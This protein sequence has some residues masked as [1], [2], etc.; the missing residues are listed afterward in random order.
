VPVVKYRTK[1]PTVCFS[2]EGIKAIGVKNAAARCKHAA[3]LCAFQKIWRIKYFVTVFDIIKILFLN[4]CTL[5]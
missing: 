4:K 1:I 2:D 5:C 3:D